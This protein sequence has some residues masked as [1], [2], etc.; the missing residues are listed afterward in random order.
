MIDVRHVG[1]RTLLD[2]TPALEGIYRQS[3]AG[4]PWSEPEAKLAQFPAQLRRQLSYRGAGGLL[5]FDGEAIVGAV[6]GWAAPEALRPDNPLD[7]ALV[8]AVTPETLGSLSAPAR[9][10]GELMVASTHRRRGIASRLLTAYVADAPR[11]WLITHRDSDARHLY[12]RA[13]WCEQVEFDTDGQPVVLLTW[14]PGPAAQ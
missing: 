6:Y 13:G 2:H 12:R 8:T 14:A 10:V 5:A 3:F 4:P 9:I 1:A 11:A 7:A